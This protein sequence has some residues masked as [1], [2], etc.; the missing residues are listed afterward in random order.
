[1]S[2]LNN[3]RTSSWMKNQAH[4]TKRRNEWLMSSW[5]IEQR[6]KQEKSDPRHQAIVADSQN[7]MKVHEIIK[8]MVLEGSS[9]QEILDSLSEHPEFEK[10][11]SYFQKW[12]QDHQNKQAKMS[13]SKKEKEEEQE[14]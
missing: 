10:Y 4:I 12:I 6:K 9:T 1:M 3:D 13:S 2:N 8:K 5:Q 11:V 14:R 7:R